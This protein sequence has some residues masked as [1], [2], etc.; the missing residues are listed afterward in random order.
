MNKYEVGLIITI[1]ISLLIIGISGH[2]VG[3][4][5]GQEDALKGKYKYSLRTNIVLETIFNDKN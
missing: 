4:R 5:D 3:Y 1:I 2:A